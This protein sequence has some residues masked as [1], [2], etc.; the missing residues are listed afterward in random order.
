MI[1]IV[2]GILGLVYG[3]FSFV[4]PDKVVDAGPLQISVDKKKSLPIPPLLGIVAVVGGVGLLAF[5]RKKA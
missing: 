1:L 2:L 3:G 5:D 4:Y